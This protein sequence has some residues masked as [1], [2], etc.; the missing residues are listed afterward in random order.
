MERKKTSKVAFLIT[1]RL[2]TKSLTTTYEH[3][4]GCALGGSE[5]HGNELLIILEL[6]RA[7]FAYQSVKMSY[8]NL[9][10]TLEF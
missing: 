10:S 8:K 3:Q 6:N 7:L 1:F 2:T 5:C 9:Y 4:L